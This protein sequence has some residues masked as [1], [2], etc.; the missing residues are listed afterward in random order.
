MIAVEESLDDVKLEVEERL[1]ETFEVD[2]ERVVLGA[3]GDI[4]AVGRQAHEVLFV[5]VTCMKKRKEK[6]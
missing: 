3:A 6:V 2:V 5:G 1:G 4:I